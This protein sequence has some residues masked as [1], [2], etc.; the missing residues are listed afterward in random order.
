MVKRKATKEATNS[1]YMKKA[2]PATTK[3][4]TATKSVAKKPHM[5]LVKGMT[6]D[7]VTL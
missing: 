6:D 7:G 4:V 2:A 1:K 3:K 5:Q